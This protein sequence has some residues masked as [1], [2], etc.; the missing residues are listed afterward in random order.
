[1]GSI[2]KSYVS[3]YR[4]LTTI[5]KTWKTV[6]NEYNKKI[7]DIESSLLYIYIY[8]IKLKRIKKNNNVKTSIKSTKFTMKYNLMEIINS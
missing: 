6:L 3:S 2:Q 5:I 4:V 1:M 8:I 7:Y